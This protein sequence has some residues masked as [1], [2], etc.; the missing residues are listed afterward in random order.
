MDAKACAQCSGPIPDGKRKDSEFCSLRCGGKSWHHR[1]KPRALQLQKESR[2]RMR[3]GVSPAQ[4]QAMIKA[5]DGR[6]AICRLQKKLN[7]DH[8]HQTGETRGLLCHRCN[9]IVGALENATSVHWQF[10]GKELA[11]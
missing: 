8:N 9:T 2:H 1:N 3:Y 5:Q 4:F 11:C 6:C 7:I 10:I